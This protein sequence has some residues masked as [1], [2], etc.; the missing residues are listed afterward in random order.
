MWHPAVSV[1]ESVL[2]TLLTLN[3]PRDFIK[4]QPTQYHDNV[5]YSQLQHSPDQ[6]QKD[7][8]Q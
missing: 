6:G 3:F 1:V 7:I 4:L 2:E 5:L 8:D